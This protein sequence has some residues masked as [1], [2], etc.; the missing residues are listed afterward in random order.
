MKISVTLSA[1]AGVAIDFGGHRV[2][3]DALH[4]QKVDGFSAVC[5]SLQKQMMQSS[6]FSNPE[7]ICYTH[8]HP[9]HFS[10]E[11]T[12]EAKTLWPNTKLYL[13]ENM[14]PEQI[15]VQG[16]SVSYREGNLTLHFFRLPHEGAQYAGCIHY[17]ILLSLE[18]K[19]ILIPGD[20][21]VAAD[22]LEQA[23]QD[24]PIDLALLNFPWLTLKKGHTFLQEVL[25]PKKTLLYHLPFEEDDIN[26]FRQAAEKALAREHSMEMQLLWN[27]LQTIV[28]DI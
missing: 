25:Q 7:C 19:H 23:V 20:C 1:N 28:L 6:A 4:D 14:F 11:L 26:G 27:P 3:V 2:W 17:G 24:V 8:C 18:G 13:P 9:D 12:A 21:Q 10:E 16:Q 15:L 5:P 22:A